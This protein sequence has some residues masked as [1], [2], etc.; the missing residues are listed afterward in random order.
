MAGTEESENF[1]IPCLL[2]P[3]SF[4]LQELMGP[5]QKVSEACFW[6]R[7]G[8]KEGKRRGHGFRFPWSV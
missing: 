3:L 7:G 6:G 2:L 8:I 1:S 4:A 5:G